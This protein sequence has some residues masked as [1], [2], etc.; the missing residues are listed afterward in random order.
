MV[1]FDYHAH[2]NYSDGSF[3]FSMAHAAERAGL[4]GIG[5]ADHCHL[6]GDER[7]RA[8]RDAF[9]FHLDLTYERRRRGI[10]RVEET[11]DLR[12]FDA[13]EIDY[14]PDEEERIDGF[15]DE[16]GFDY[17]VGSVH[18]VNGR[19]VQDDGEFRG[20]DEATRAAVV[21]AYYD[22][23]VELI[24]SELFDIAAHLDLVE[25][26][27]SLRGFSTTEQYERVAAALADSATVPEINAGRA[28]GDY[29]EFHPSPGLL[30]ALQSHDVEFVV[31]TD[32]HDP[33]EIGRRVDALETH[34]DELGVE[35]ITL[36]I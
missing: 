29:G 8:N 1:R 16:A 5:I 6:S 13:V 17:A 9:G 28:L 33:E 27:P 12:V 2:S 7:L 32:S 30:S 26:T 31:G 4:D 25:R 14:L 23:V 18:Q 20:D 35:P 19:N 11:H 34:L 21:E 3:L 22:T 15:L 24:E 36:D 10:Q